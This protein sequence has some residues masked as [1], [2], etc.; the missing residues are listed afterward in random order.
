MSAIA[1]EAD[2]YKIQAVVR[3]C[4]EIG[5]DLLLRIDD[6]KGMTEKDSDNAMAAVR[7][8]GKGLQLIESKE[9]DAK[10]SKLIRNLK[11][12]PDVS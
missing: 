3:R 2:C 6:Q 10:V 11:V 7:W 8:L 1:T 12:G 5:R 4:L 9:G